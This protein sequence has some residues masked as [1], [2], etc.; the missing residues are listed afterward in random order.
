M[1]G[2]RLFRY[3]DVLKVLAIFLASTVG[4]VLWT[5]TAR[6]IL[7]PHLVGVLTLVGV[8]GVIVVGVLLLCKPMSRLLIWHDRLSAIVQPS[9]PDFNP[10]NQEK[11]AGSS[12]IDHG[13]NRLIESARSWQSLNQLQQSI[14]NQLLSLETRTAPPLLDALTDG[15]ATIDSHGTITF[16]NTT[17]AAISGASSADV[18][19]GRSLFEL[20]TT[21]SESAAAMQALMPQAPLEWNFETPGGRRILN[22]RYRPGRKSDQSSF[23]FV[24]TI[25]DVTQ[26]RLAEAMRDQFLAAATHEFRTPLANIRAYAE[27][28]HD[29]AE[30][31]TDSRKRFYNVIQSES[32]RLSQLV[33]DLLDISRMQA[34][35]LSLEPTETDLG[36]LAEEVAAKVQGELQSKGIEFQCELPP[37]LP[38]KIVVD[39]SK[40][41]AALVNLLGNA[42]KYTP[43][44]GKVTFRV[45]VAANRLQ[46]QICDTGIG[47]AS[48]ELP[49]VFERFYRSSD[50]RVRE[51]TGSGLGLAL[52]QEVARLHGGEVTAESQLDQ[53][54]T[55]CMT[56]PVDS[57]LGH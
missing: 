38:P 28:L 49:H 41:S 26:Q 9:C 46:F 53:G 25:R 45:D 6:V 5:I 51:L 20:L 57:N 15:V 32:V 4:A 30:L 47:I 50:D 13:W 18:L 29:S 17:L 10:W 19:M 12:A 56:I 33:D 27:S 39:K 34:G 36:R 21:D 22:G 7:T 52:T 23:A 54:S 24:W 42:A 35:A 3:P 37:K 44:G 55:F 2:I 1:A 31:D 16:A 8:V 48:D 11:A 43:A 14:Q 40:L